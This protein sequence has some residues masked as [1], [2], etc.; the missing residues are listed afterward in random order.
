M[1]H[2][3]SFSEGEFP[4]EFCNDNL[5]DCLND[6]YSSNPDDNFL[7]YSYRN[8]TQVLATR[9]IILSQNI[10]ILCTCTNAQSFK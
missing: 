2:R 10:K 1:A 6:I 3:E 7:E 9:P 8:S 4:A 5:S